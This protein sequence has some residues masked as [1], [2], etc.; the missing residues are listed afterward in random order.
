M[1]TPLNGSILRAFSILGLFGED[2]LEITA[3]IVAAELGTNVATS[4]RLL[5]TL[6]EAGALISYRRGTYCLGP[7][8]EALGRLAAGSDQLAIRSVPHIRRLS[9]RLNESVMVARLTRGGPTCM[10][11]A[12]SNRP[13][14]VNINVG[15]V[16]SISASAQGK[17]WLAHMDP[18][19]RKKWLST[20]AT[21]N[22]SEMDQ[23]R[24][25]GYA[26]NRGEIE[27][28]IGA[29][30]VAIHDRSGTLVATLSTFG[31]LNRFNDAMVEKALPL[32]RA[33]AAQIA[34]EI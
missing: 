21:V 19:E 34:S 33:T 1:G 14:S 13:I 5:V 3:A 20:N 7:A 2:R 4:H 10:A 22:E 25:D 11:V 31:M 26:R 9:Q 16:L 30:A 28:D 17:I 18:A 27:P 29:L 12:V 8:L 6:E 24:A 15:T 32:L 23:I